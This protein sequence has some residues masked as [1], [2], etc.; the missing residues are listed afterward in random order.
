MVFYE[1]IESKPDKFHLIL[2]E[3]DCTKS[4][5]VGPYEIKN[6][7]CE[8][9]LGIT[10]DNQLSFNDHVS[11]LCKKASQK[12]HALCR[13]SKYMKTDQLRITMNAFVNSQFGYCPI[14]WMFHS[15]TINK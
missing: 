12:L 4:I 8:K 13:I 9:L 15:R 5:F 3:F 1:C 10:I 7:N 14:V 2:S 11:Y 6:S